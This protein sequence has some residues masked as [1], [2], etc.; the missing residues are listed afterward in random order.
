MILTITSHQNR[1]TA[2]Q[3]LQLVQPQEMEFN[4]LQYPNQ[5][6]W[7]RNVINWKKRR[8]SNSW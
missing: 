8:N 1:F 6:K 4:T 3:E 7:V 2:I 5:I